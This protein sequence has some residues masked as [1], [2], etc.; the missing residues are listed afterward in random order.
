MFYSASLS[1]LIHTTHHLKSINQSRCGTLDFIPRVRS[2]G[3]DEHTSRGQFWQYIPIQIQQNMC[4]QTQHSEKL[5]TARVSQVAL[6]IA[7]CCRCLLEEVLGKCL[8]GMHTHAHAHSEHQ[9]FRGSQQGCQ[10]RLADGC[11]RQAGAAA[12]GGKAHD[13]A[14]VRPDSRG[15]G[16]DVAKSPTAIESRR[17]DHS[18]AQAAPVGRRSARAPT[19][20]SSVNLGE[21]PS[22]HQICRA[23]RVATRTPWVSERRLGSVRDQGYESVRAHRACTRASNKAAARRGQHRQGKGRGEK[24][25]SNRWLPLANAVANCLAVSGSETKT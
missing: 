3:W 24:Q 14:D 15:K 10:V 20:P 2:E 18:G 23:V 9:S 11:V 13:V 5:S 17:I 8:C 16:F 25:R 19:A 1:K 22:H 12:T 6:L 21:M 4:A 7:S